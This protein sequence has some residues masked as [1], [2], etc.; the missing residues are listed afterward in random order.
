M[1]KICPNCKT[2][3]MDSAEFC[4]NCGTEL[5]KFS[6]NVPPK[7]D[8]PSQP[9]S[10]GWWGKQTTLVKIISVVGVCCVGLIV[11]IVLAGIFFPDATTFNINTGNT[12]ALTQTFSE[13]GLTFNYPSDWTNSS[14]KYIDS[15][16]SIVQSLGTL[17][18]PDGLLLD[19]SKQDMTETVEAA[20]EGTK[21]NLKTIPSVQILSETTKTVNGLKIYELI[22][23]Y[24]DTST[25]QEAKS[26]YVITGKDGQVAYYLQFIDDPNDFSSD[27]SLMNSI[28]NTI[29]IQ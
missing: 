2:E 13:S 17:A 4:Q 19:V 7:E 16:T 26:L 28:V 18:S 10:G 14:V 1:T 27:Q 29:K 3:N 5:P 8:T 6:Y 23:T 22:V 9:K 21:T 24:T 25:N 11:L 15:S 20:K 12:P